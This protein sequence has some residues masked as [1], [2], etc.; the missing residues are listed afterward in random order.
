MH[1]TDLQALVFMVNIGNSCDFTI[2]PIDTR[3]C[4]VIFYWHTSVQC[5]KLVK[6]VTRQHGG[7]PL[8]VVRPH[9][10]QTAHICPN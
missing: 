9:E 8:K 4:K 7:L 2:R 3:I 5:S 1:C 6:I 10:N